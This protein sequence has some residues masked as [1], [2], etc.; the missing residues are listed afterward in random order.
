MTDAHTLDRKFVYAAV[1]AAVKA[2]G[3]DAIKTGPFFG[4][5]ERR[6]KDVK[7]AA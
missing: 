3:L 4:V 5:G 1:E 6:T 7:K 2:V